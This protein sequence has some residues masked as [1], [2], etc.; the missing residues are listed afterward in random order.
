MKV[1]NRSGGRGPSTPASGLVCTIFPRFC[2]AKCPAGTFAVFPSN[3]NPSRTRGK[4]CVQV[5]PFGEHGYACVRCI[6][7]ECRLNSSHC[8]SGETFDAKNCRCVKR[9]PEEPRTPGVPGSDGAANNN[10]CIGSCSGLRLSY[11][12]VCPRAYTTASGQR[13]CQSTSTQ[14]V[15]SISEHWDTG[16]P[17]GTTNPFT[18]CPEPTPNTV[19]LVRTTSFTNTARIDKNS[20][21]VLVGHDIRPTERKVVARCCLSVG[22]IGLVNLADDIDTL[23]PPDLATDGADRV[24]RVPER[25]YTRRF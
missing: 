10:N 18:P 5:L 12:S 23:P 11:I 20:G 14:P 16:F 4:E 24:G 15:E 7:K 13:A 1:G 2:D 6:Q 25:C 22:G 21:R 9:G 3:P 19:W 8:A 17:A